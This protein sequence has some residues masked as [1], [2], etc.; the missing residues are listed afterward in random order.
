MGLEND[1]REWD[2]R[3]KSKEILICRMACR[4]CRR[5]G[6]YREPGALPFWNLMSSN[7]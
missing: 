6:I 5:S 2:S 3:T 7:N 1:R 4:G